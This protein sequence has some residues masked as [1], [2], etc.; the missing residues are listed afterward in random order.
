MKQNHL[1]F[2]YLR[3]ARHYDS[4][5]GTNESDHALGLCPHGEDLD[6]NFL[7]LWKIFGSLLVPFHLSPI[8]LDTK[9]KGVHVFSVENMDRLHWSCL[10]AQKEASPP[11]LI[12]LHS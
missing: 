8:E 4:S 10:Y 7:I 1:S 9:N 6:H 5:L 3:K 11:P 12:S 2:Y